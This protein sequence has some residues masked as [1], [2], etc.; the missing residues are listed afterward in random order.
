MSIAGVLIDIGRATASFEEVENI[1]GSLISIE[2]DAT[3]EETHNWTNTVTSS[4]VEDGS[5]V[6][7]N[8]LQNP[9]Q[10]TLTGIITNS[11]V[12]LDD[13]QTSSIDDSP[14]ET[15]VNRVFGLLSD[16]MDKGGLLTVFTRYKVYSDMAITSINIPRTV[17]I[18]EAIVFTI[19]FLKI[20][21]VSTQNVDVP[22]GI[23]A[24]LDKKAGASVQKKTMPQ[25]NDGAV[26]ATDLNKS[27]AA[28]I[29]DGTLKGIGGLISGIKSAVGL[30]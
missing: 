12:F 9:R 16:L 2:F 8:I 27:G 5:D 22:A 1:D 17:G 15:R 21:I 19:E 28:S 11:P 13:S 10:L 4:P 30:P 29:A 7:D 20:R 14:Q 6:T 18:G 24:K 25:K 26:P 3:T 23:S